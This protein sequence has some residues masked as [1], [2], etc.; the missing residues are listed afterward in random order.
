MPNRRPFWL[1]TVFLTAATLSTSLCARGL[2]WNFLADAYL[3]VA[4]DH[5]R[6]AVNGQHDPF[7]AVQLRMSGDAVFLERVVARYTNGTSEELLIGHRILP[8]GTQVMNLTGESRV[9]QSVE[10]WYYQ[11]AWEHR[12]RVRLYGTR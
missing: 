7:R 6:I 2:L 5:D 10:L 12:P 3:D 1:I 4:H 11:E 8:E 9:L